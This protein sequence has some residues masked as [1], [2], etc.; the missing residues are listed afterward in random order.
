MINPP[1]TREEARKLTFGPPYAEYPFNPRYCAFEIWKKN[2][3]STYQCQRKAGH[4]PDNLYCKQHAK[5][6]EA[7]ESRKKEAKP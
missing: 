1:R 3:P 7:I 2:W 5:M 6:I 4:G